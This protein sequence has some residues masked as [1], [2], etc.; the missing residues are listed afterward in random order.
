MDYDQLSKN[1]KLKGK[2]KEKL[3]HHEVIVHDTVPVEV[4]CPN[5]IYSLSKF[6]E[7]QI[8][9]G[10]ILGLLLV[11]LLIIYGISKRNNL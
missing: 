1:F 3:I 6:E 9:L 5:P 10:R 2:V 8:W 4:P 11:I 7:F